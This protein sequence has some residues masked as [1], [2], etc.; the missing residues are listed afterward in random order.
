MPG[1]E[2]FHAAEPSVP[3][4]RLLYNELGCVNCHGGDDGLFASDIAVD[5]DGAAHFVAVVELFGDC[6]G[7]GDIN[8]KNRNMGAICG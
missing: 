6:F 7:P 5:G 2:R 1:F 8:I 3:G 4:G